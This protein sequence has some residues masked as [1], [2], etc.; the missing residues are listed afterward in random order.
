MTTIE[1]LA[2][3]E[4]LKGDSICCVDT[5]AAAGRKREITW[6]EL[7]GQAN[8]LANL[9]LGRGVRRGGRVALLLMSGTES[10]A[11][12]SG[13]I[14]SGAVAVP[15]DY[16]CGSEEILRCLEASGAEALVFGSEFQGRVE[17]MAGRMTGVKLSLYVGEGAS[18]AAESYREL[19]A[20]CSSRDPLVELAEEEYEYVW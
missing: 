10:M 5:K 13:I 7:D 9:L 3:N 15:I 2:R 4:F 14:K 6:S 17:A 16:R 20:C 18:E 1:V 11:I 8:R 12:Y 19:T